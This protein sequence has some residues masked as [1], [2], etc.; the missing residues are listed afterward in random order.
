MLLGNGEPLI[1]MIAGQ[2]LLTALKPWEGG[3]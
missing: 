1:K 3:A 2:K